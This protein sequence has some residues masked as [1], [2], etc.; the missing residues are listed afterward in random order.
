[1]T[2]VTRAEQEKYRGN[3]LGDNGELFLVRCAACHR[4]NW[5]PAVASGACAWCGWG[6]CQHSWI[7]AHPL[8]GDDTQMYVCE[9]CEGVRR[10]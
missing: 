4:E 3:F 9:N 5:A 6:Q 2:N 10:D 7:K 8:T 1:M